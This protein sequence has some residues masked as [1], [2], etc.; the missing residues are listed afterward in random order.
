MDNS[1]WCMSVAQVADAML[2][3]K[4]VLDFHAGLCIIK[5]YCIVFARSDQQILRSMKVD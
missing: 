1:L 4:Q 2:L 3:A 5:P